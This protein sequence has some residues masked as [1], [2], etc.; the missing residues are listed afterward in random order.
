MSVRGCFQGV[1]GFKA[2]EVRL[3]EINKEFTYLTRESDIKKGKFILS[4]LSEDGLVKHTTAPNPSAKNNFKKLEDALPVMENMILSNDHCVHP[5]SPPDCNTSDENNNSMDFEFP[6]EHSCYACDFVA[7]HR[8][9]L[10]D[11]ERKHTVKE[12]PHCHKYIP[13]TSHRSHVIKCQNAPPE[14][15]HT[16]VTINLPGSQLFAVMWRFTTGSSNVTSA[17]RATRTRRPSRGTGRLTLVGSSSARTATKHSV[18]SLLVLGIVR[19][20]IG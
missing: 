6:K 18:P 20:I 3:R 8:R 12:C 4:W 14:V 9:E 15:I 10:N 19:I 1:M 5:I 7:G 16:N 13:Y 2:T 11:H 17:Q